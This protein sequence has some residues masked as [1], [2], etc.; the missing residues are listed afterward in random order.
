VDGIRSLPD[1]QIPRQIQ[2][3]E[4]GAVEDRWG[5][6]EQVEQVGEKEEE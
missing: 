5:E 4:A 3:L 1:E 2:E 6:G